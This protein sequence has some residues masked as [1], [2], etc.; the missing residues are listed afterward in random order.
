MWALGIEDGKEWQAQPQF[1]PGLKKLEQGQGQLSVLP[2]AAIEEL[3][4]GVWWPRCGGMPLAEPVPP[5]T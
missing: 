1:P 3:L 4:A 5:S 2:L